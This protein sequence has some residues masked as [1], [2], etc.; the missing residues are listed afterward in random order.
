MYCVTSTMY[1][2]MNGS[3]GK[4]PQN[5]WLTKVLGSSSQI[6]IFCQNMKGLGSYHFRGI[7]T[8]LFYNNNAEI[9]NENKTKTKCLLT[10]LQIEKLLYISSS[11]NCL[12]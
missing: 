1:D 5:I 11:I 6:A 12:W 10:M 7:R 2:C 4:Y 8:N 9:F 3:A